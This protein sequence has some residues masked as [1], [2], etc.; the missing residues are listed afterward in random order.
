[1]EEKTEKKRRTHRG[2]WWKIPVWTLT[3]VITLTAATIATALWLLTPERLTAIVR[4]YGTEYLHEGRVDVGRVELTWWS[5]FPRLELTVDSL[6]VTSESGQ[7][8]DSAATLLSVDRFHGAV[9]LAALAEG[10]IAINDVTIVRPAACIY[11]GDDGRSNLD[12]LPTSA[13]TTDT[14]Q[15]DLIIPPIALD[16]FVIEGDA[17]LS[18]ISVPDSLE[19]SLNLHLLAMERHGTPRYG[20]RFSASPQTNLAALPDTFA[21]GLDG[22]MRWDPADPLAIGL[23]DFTMSTGDLKVT[24]DTE[25]RMDSALTIESLNAKIGPISPEYLVKL[26]RMQPDMGEKVPAVECGGML[27]VAARLNRPYQLADTLLPDAT[28]SLELT[29]GP[30][31]VPSMRARFRNVGLLVEADIHPEDLNSSVVRLKKFNATGTY[32]ATS[33][34]VEGTATDLLDDPLL[35][36]K[37]HG[38]IQLEQLPPPLLRAIGAEMSGRLRAD[39]GFK[40]RLSQLNAANFHKA[41]LG[42]MVRLQDFAVNMPADS[43]SAMAGNVEVRFGSSRTLRRGQVRADSL[44]T[45]SL[46]VDTAAVSLPEFN[47]TIARL[48]VGLGCKNDASLSDTTTITPMGG[49]IEMEKVR[50]VSNTDSTRAMMRGLSANASI[51]RFNGDKKIP[52][53]ALAVDVKRMIYASGLSR[54]SLSRSNIAMNMHLRPKK[55]RQTQVNDSIRAARRAARHTADSLDQKMEVMDFGLD[56]SSASLLRRL[57]LDGQLSAKSGRV[58]SPYYPLRMTMRNLDFHFTADSIALNSVELKAGQSDFKAH[59]TVSNIKRSIGFARAGAPLKIEFALHADTI[60]VNELTQA[61]F[62]GAALA[63]RTDS[64][65]MAAVSLD[66]DDNTLESSVDSMAVTEIAAVL[67]PVNID[68]DLHFT[69][70]NILYSTMLMHDFSGALLINHGAVSLHQMHASTDIG[71]VDLNALYYAPSAD[72]IDFAMGLK[73]NRF[74][75]NRVISLMPA[76]DSI[77]PILNGIGGIIDVGLGATVKLDSAMNLKT[78]SLHAMMNMTGDSLVVLDDATFKTM[79]KWLMFKDKQRNMIDHMA[80]ELSVQNSM[81]ELYPFIFDFDRYRLGVM[82]NNDLDLNLNYHVSVLKSPLP[83]KFGINITG[84]ADDMKI[85]M[86]KARYKE[87]KAAKKVA[88]ADSARVNLVNEMRTAFMRGIEA[89][90]VAPLKV[91]SHE[92]LEEVNEATDTLTQEQQQLLTDSISNPR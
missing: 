54:I 69:A 68:A 19:A 17:P 36:G 31:S 2:L 88:L 12:M 37:F 50:F 64:T 47:A 33:I 15:S 60:N 26:A 57:E 3:V 82:G 91:E 48:N 89:A 75:I 42:G 59:G 35:T 7:I 39:T 72:D 71:S 18:F 53:L 83:F 63:A 67:V 80:V 78:P 61:A 8:P 38:N 49:K 41:K 21:I 13:D 27:T 76:L 34:S 20:I 45:V 6:A 90:R 30:L 87:K 10:T 40:F 9:D 4:K 46:M 29:D 73:L 5:T 70:D 62:R 66:L 25:V 43:L 23:Q 65:A 11:I 1:M 77:M 32:G 44:L 16:R 52:Q 55:E 74:R 84:P 28:V 56:K 58:F 85:R 79:A 81:L 14:D 24:F 86:G 92:K 22:E 51:T